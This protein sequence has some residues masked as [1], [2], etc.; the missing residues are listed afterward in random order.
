MV[1]P[2][3]SQYIPCMLDATWEVAVNMVVKTEVIEEE[4]FWKACQSEGRYSI[5]VICN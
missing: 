3:V 2:N 4:N 5:E 1:P